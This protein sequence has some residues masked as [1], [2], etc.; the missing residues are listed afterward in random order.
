MNQQW[1]GPVFENAFIDP[2]YHQ[3]TFEDGHVNLVLIESKEI[4]VEILFEA[5]INFASE[6]F[7]VL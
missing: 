3:L 1:V 2:F 7:L 6:H 4:P 5:L